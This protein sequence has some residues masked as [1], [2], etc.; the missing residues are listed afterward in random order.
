MQ[1]AVEVVVTQAQSDQIDAAFRIC[2]GG[3]RFIRGDW[4]ARFDSIVAEIIGFDPPAA[5]ST[6][7][8]D[9]AV[10]A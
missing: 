3:T 4:S 1:Q 5:F 8:A 9:V 7:I 6:R 10:S 2:S